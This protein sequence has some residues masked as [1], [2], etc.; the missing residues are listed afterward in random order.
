MFSSAGD[1]LARSLD[2]SAETAVMESRERR[3]SGRWRWLRGVID[4]GRGS[5]LSALLPLR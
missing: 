3:G 5:M 1:H 2:F 4:E